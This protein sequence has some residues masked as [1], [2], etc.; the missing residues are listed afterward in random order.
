MPTNFNSYEMILDGM[1]VGEARSAAA[2]SVLTNVPKPEFVFF[3]DY[4]VL[5]HYDCL[6]KLVYRARHFPAYDIFAGVYCTKSDTPEPLVYKDGYGHGPY[7]DWTIGDLLMEGIVGVH[8]G[9]TLIRTSLIERMIAGKGKEFDLFQTVRKV[10]HKEDGSTAAERG[11]EDLFFCKLATEE[12]GAKILVDTS[13]LAGHQEISTGRVFGLPEESGPVKRA[14]WLRINKDRE[15]ANGQP[16]LKKAL[17]IGAGDH[18]REWEGHETFTTDIRPE[19]KPTYVMD[20]LA[21]N[22]PDDEFD[23]VTTSH[24]LE[25]IPRFEQERIWAEMFRVCKP[26][27][28]TEH[29]VP[30]LDWAAA[31]IAEDG[32]VD[33]HIMNVLYG[34]QELHEFKRELNLHYFGYT[35]LIAKELAEL[36]G[37]VDVAVADWR[38]DPD[39]NYN[40]KIVGTKPPAKDSEHAA[41]C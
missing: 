34:A 37:F 19:S 11:T 35:K 38:D 17:D 31:R 12:F 13:V 4:D 2:R 30:S 41:V 1:E 25:H 7:W 40:L 29:I 21:L 23:L 8:M 33:E 10:H 3:L 28:R 36:A 26:G 16:P 27:G 39:L 32:Q 24:H 9:L 20:S 22:L 5:P 15:K 18:Y 14:K 6:Q